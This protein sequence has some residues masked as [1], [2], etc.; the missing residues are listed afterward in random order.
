MFSKR[1]FEFSD[2]ISPNYPHSYP[3]PQTQSSTDRWH[4]PLCHHDVVVQQV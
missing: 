4:P 2:L 3:Q 1:I